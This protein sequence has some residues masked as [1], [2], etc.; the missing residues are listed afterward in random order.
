VIKTVIRL[1]IV[2]VL[3]NATWRVGTAYAKHYR[4]TDAVTQTTQYRSDKTD[5]QIHDRVF[6]LAAAHDIPVTDENLTVTHREYHTVVEGAY[7]RPI[8]L[9]PGFIY[10]WPFTV[11]VD[12]FT[13]EVSR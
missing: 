7:K 13:V 3:A 8:E 10:A 9:F 1:A 2:A 4:F 6:E 11:H 12:T 5:A